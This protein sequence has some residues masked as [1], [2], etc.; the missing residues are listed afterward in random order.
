M[1]DTQVVV[2]DN[3]IKYVPLFFLSK[4]YLFITQGKKGKQCLESSL[5]HRHDVV[6]Q[7]RPQAR[8]EPRQRFC[9]TRGSEDGKDVE[10]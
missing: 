10:D 9:Y 1:S 3:L 8:G 5:P 7:E 2:C 6:S 4:P